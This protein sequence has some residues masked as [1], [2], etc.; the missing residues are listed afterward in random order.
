VWQSV[1]NGEKMDWLSRKQIKVIFVPMKTW[2]FL[3]QTEL[4]L[5]VFFWVFLKEEIDFWCRLFIFVLC[6]FHWPDVTKVTRLWKDYGLDTSERDKC[7]FCNDGII[8]ICYY[9][10]SAVFICLVKPFWRRR[11]DFWC[12]VGQW[13]ASGDQAGGACCWGTYTH[14]HLKV[15]QTH[16]TSK[17]VF[18][19]HRKIV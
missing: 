17:L 12:L 9:N 19:R 7:D 4:W 8:E 2:R 6:L 11:I 15:D 16:P 13:V 10:S 14:T 3:I 18:R 1:I 5:L